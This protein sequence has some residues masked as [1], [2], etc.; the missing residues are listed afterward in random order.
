VDDEPDVNEFLLEM[1]VRKGSD[2]LEEVETV[3]DEE[4]WLEQNPV[5]DDDAVEMFPEGY[6]DDVLPPEHEDHLI[7]EEAEELHDEFQL[8]DGD[9]YEFERII[10]H[11]LTASGSMLTVKYTGDTKEETLKGSFLVLKKDVPLELAR[12]IH[13]KVVEDSRQGHYNTWAKK[14]IKNHGRTI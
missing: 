3:E 5:T 7:A 9:N 13:D 11:K 6:A 4:S 14:V 8:E 10:D 2:L 1:N 12:Y